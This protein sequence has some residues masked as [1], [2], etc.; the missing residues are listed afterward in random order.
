MDVLGAQA[1]LVAVLDE[2]LGGVDH[3]D[4]LAGVGVFLV[5]HEDA[6]GDAGAVEEVGRQADDA[7]DVAA[8]DD[9]PADGGLG[10]APEQHAVRENDRALARALEAGEDVQQEGVVAVLLRRDAEREAADTG[11]WPGRSR[12]SRPWW[13]RGNW[14]RRSRRS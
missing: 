8:P 5:Q 12:C 1:V 14:R 6:G 11:R 13:R 10:A 2:A 9:L 4:A 3:E 7:L